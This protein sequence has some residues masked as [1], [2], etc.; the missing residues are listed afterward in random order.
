MIIHMNSSSD[1]MA[2]GRK[3]PEL[4]EMHD[5]VNQNM[6]GIQ[7]TCARPG[8]EL[9]FTEDGWNTF[10][11]VRGEIADEPWVMFCEDC[12]DW[13]TEVLAPLR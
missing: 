3:H 11:A 4:L 1:L 13:L 6:C 10:V 2:A 9:G 8:R 7:V 5:G 12:F